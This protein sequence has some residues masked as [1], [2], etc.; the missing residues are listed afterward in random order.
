MSGEGYLRESS[1]TSFLGLR[2]FFRYERDHPNYGRQNRRNNLGESCIRPL[3]ER[4]CQ[5]A[6]LSHSKKRYPIDDQACSHFQRIIQYWFR[7]YDLSGAVKIFIRS[8]L[9]AP[10]L[11]NRNLLGMHVFILNCS[12]GSSRVLNR[13]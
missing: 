4:G 10:R 3:G 12:W 11:C 5:Y 6:I 8:R 2:G 7:I 1:H 13:G 9:L